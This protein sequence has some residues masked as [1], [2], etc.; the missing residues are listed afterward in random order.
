MSAE[1]LVRIDKE[2]LYPFCEPYAL[3]LDTVKIS[4]DDFNSWQAAV[5]EFLRWNKLIIEMIDEQNP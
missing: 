5:K 1:I 2:E 4:E 3:G